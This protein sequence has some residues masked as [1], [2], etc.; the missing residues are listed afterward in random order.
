[1]EMACLCFI[2]SEISAGRLENCRL[3]LSESSILLMWSLLE[4]LVGIPT[5]GLST[6]PGLPHNMATGLQGLVW[7]KL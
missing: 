2:L 7:R 3:G 5:H 4:L 6:W 1:M